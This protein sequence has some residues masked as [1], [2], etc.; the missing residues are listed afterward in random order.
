MKITLA[1]NTA[2]SGCLAS[3]AL[4]AKDIIVPSG[5]I[6]TIQQGVDAAAPGDT[7]RVR[8]GTYVINYQGGG[9][10]PG[11]YIGPDKSRLQLKADGAPGAVKIVGVGTVIPG[12][13]WP[14]I[15]VSAEDVLVEGLDISG[16]QTGISSGAATPGARITQ[17][18]IHALQSSSTSPS[19]A[20]SSGPSNEVDHNVVYGCAY[21]IFLSGWSAEGPNWQAHI[22]HNQVT[23]VQDVGIFLWQAPG[24]QVDHNECDNNG[25]IGMYLAGSPGCTADH[26]EANG[27]VQAGIAV[28]NSPSCEVTNNDAKDNDGVG[29]SVGSSCGSRFSHNFAEGNGQTDLF[30]PNWDSDPACNTYSVNHAE[31]AVPS[32]QLWDVR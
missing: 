6:Q 28:G 11:I 19:V 4:Q 24:C 31:A 13:S 22:H 23:G 9:W 18:T 17:N 1:F 15:L 7:V 30:A 12:Y 8:P 32:L 16:F 14:A 26:N 27:N 21:G 29:I 25:E 5:T 3:F 10:P 2:L 20:I